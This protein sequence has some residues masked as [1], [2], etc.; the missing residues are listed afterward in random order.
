MVIEPLR[1]IAVLPTGNGLVE[2][3]LSEVG[4]V[5]TVKRMTKAATSQQPGVAQTVNI[6]VI[7]LF[8]TDNWLLGQELALSKHIEKHDR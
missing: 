7:L 8:M 2:D 4:S 6:S 3:D 1:R 5:V